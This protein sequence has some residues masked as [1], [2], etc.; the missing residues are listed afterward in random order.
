M[1]Y[2]RLGGT[3]LEVSALG[4]GCGAVGGLL[5]RGERS[6]MLRTVARAIELGVTYFDTAAV[7][8]N[9]QSE[10]SLGWVLEE[11][12]AKVVVGTK[13]QLRAEEM[14]DIE[15]AVVASVERSLERLRMECVDLIQLHN[16][17]VS[18]RPPDRAWVNRQDVQAAAAAFQM[19]QEQGKARY[20][21]INGLGDTE[22]LHQV[23]GTVG[24]HSIQSCYN[25]LN[26]SAGQR[27]PEGFPFQDYG[28]L[29]DRAAANQAGVIAIRV[30]AGG[31]LSGSAARHANASP[32]VDPIA[33]H[34]TFGEDVA[35]AQRFEF[36]VQEGYA[37]SLVEA[38]I[39][40]AIGK[41]EV[42]TALVGLSNLAQL[43]QA[44]AAAERGPLPAEASERLRQAWASL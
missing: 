37:E 36:L 11:L 28:G 25:L 19:L 44:V 39:R 35:L 18:A 23:V 24:A 10:A 1:E 12:G 42:S 14:D 30:L 7:Y 17:V 15:R 3:D 16:R 31:A 21:G 2:R 34:T 26:P 38:A 13:V 20:W 29:I 6:D 33:T 40:F 9:G 8:G 22:V 5:V 32:T 41:R 27:V 4:F 43:E